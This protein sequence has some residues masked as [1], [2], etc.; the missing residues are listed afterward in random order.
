MNY[1][2]LEISL[3]DY[4]LMVRNYLDD[5]NLNSLKTI[6][7]LKNLKDKE[8]K[9][10]ISYIKNLKIFDEIIKKDETRNKNDE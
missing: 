1:C 10:Y 8:K 4:E 9:R 2:Y 3:E 5:G 7:A 6:M